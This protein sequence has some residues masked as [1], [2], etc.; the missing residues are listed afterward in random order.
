MVGT[1]G[2]RVFLLG[3]AL[4]VGVTLLVVQLIYRR[5]PDRSQKKVVSVGGPAIALVG[6]RGL[7][8]FGQCAKW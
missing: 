8:K 4:T 5:N 3:I 6:Q 1:I 2:T 7:R